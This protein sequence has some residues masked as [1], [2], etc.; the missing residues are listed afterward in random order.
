MEFDIAKYYRGGEISFS[1]S[2]TYNDLSST[3]GLGLPIVDSKSVL[4]NPEGSALMIPYNDLF[5][6]QGIS[7][8]L[9]PIKSY[10]YI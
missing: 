6:V 3:F 5:R 7:K 1:F 4:N 9:V 10:I 2:T 8:L